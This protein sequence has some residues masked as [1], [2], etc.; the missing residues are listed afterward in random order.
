MS[1]VWNLLN[2][3]PLDTVTDLSLTL[4]GVG[5]SV[6]GNGIGVFM[7]GSDSQVGMLLGVGTLGLDPSSHRLRPCFPLFAGGLG[8]SFVYLSRA[9]EYIYFQ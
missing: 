4:E 8:Q 6:T 3:Y 1:V 2:F 7:F 9:K 5:V